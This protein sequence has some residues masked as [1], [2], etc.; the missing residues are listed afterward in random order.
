MVNFFV[1][2]L[3]FSVTGRVGTDR[4]D[5]FYFLSFLALANLFWPVTK[6]EWCFSVFLI[7]LLFFGIFYYRSGRN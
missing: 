3:E 6:P 4:N 5:N 1:I 2:F 7:F